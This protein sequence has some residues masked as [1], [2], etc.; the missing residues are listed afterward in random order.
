M[1]LLS[2]QVMVIDKK[3]D[4]NASTFRPLDQ[5]IHSNRKYAGMGYMPCKGYVPCQVNN[6]YF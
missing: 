5:E 3:L 4:E 1:I 6:R 2:L